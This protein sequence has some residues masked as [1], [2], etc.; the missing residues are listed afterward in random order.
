MK[1]FYLTFLLSISQILSAQTETNPTNLQDQYRLQIKKTTSLPKIDGVLDEECWKTAQ[2]TSEFW[3]VFPIDKVH[4]KN[5]TEVKVCYDDK[6]LYVSAICFDT[7]QYIIQTL[8]RDTDPFDSD[9]FGVVIDPVNKKTNGFLFTV[10]PYNVQAEDLLSASNFGD[11]LS[12]S[13]DNKWYSATKRLP[14]KWIVEMAIPLSSLRFDEGNKTW[15]INFFREDLK[16]NTSNI[17]SP[18]PLQ[19]ENIDFGYLGAIV[20]EE[21]PKKPE[22]NFSIIPYMTGGLASTNE[23]NTNTTS[24]ANI[25]LDAK[26]SLNASLNLDLTINPDFSQIEVDRQV[27]NLTR[28]NLFFPERRTFFLENDDIFSSY[29][30]PP[31]RPFYSRTIGLD[32]NGNSIPIIAGA[33]ISGNLSDKLRIGFMN[34]QTSTKAENPAQNYTALSLNRRIWKRTSIKGYFLNK[35]SALNDQQQKDNPL[36]KYGRNIGG[37][38]SYSDA[39]GK[40]NFWSGYHL[41]IKPTIKKDNHMYQIG[42]G[43]FGSKFNVFVDYST[44]QTDYYADMGFINRIEN[45]TVQGT[46]YESG[47][48]TIRNG[49]AQ[50]YAETEYTHRPKDKKVVAYYYG[51]ENLTI[52]N[53]D[54]TLNEQYN[55]FRIGIEFKNTSSIRFRFEPQSVNLLYYTDLPSEKPLEPGHY[56]YN[57]ASIKFNTDY[58][59][60][61][62]V[63]GGLLAGGFYNGTIKQANISASVR[64]QPWGSFSVDLE[65]N[66][67]KFPVG[68]GDETIFLVSPRSEISFSNSIFWTTFLQFNTQRNNFNINTRLQYRYKPLSDF[69]LVYTDN[70]FTDPLFKNK[71]RGLVFKLNYWLSK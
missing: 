51:V 45:Q 60:L 18:R 1:Y 25:G 4:S 5:K 30:A 41:S 32:K 68:Y 24:K 66:Q 37:E 42:G 34:M 13:W 7:D 33:R 16:T 31:F 28:F 17:W 6:F 10:S 49:Y 40:I 2:T 23:S 58:R 36:D 44:V 15:G 61:F 43:Y 62:K 71:N 38:F 19:F 64:K 20:W 11:D 21:A 22:G 50:L 57:Q 65:L 8:K 47:Y 70:Y 9:C 26:I 27:T 29:G 69:F 35:E 54:S 56:A 3:Q 59:K 67:L 53:P 48:K 55:K 63:E 52:R 46:S 12:F 39:T 14:T